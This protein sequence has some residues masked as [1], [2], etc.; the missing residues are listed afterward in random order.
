MH[1]CTALTAAFKTVAEVRLALAGEHPKVREAR[2]SGP[3][4][5]NALGQFGSGSR[6]EAVL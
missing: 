5:G 6:Q 1:E 3:R 4:S 2:S